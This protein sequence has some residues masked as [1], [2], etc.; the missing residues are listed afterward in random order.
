MTQKYLTCQEQRDRL[1]LMPTSTSFSASKLNQRGIAPIILVI[2]L[3]VV[4]GGV[5]GVAYQSRKEIKVRRDQTSEVRKLE[6]SKATTSSENKDS[7]VE[8]PFKLADQ[9]LEQKDPGLPQFSFCPPD[10][11]SKDKRKLYCTL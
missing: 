11:W 1:N 4:I 8:K 3:T 10:G 6:G 9:P 7:G 2:I 5:A